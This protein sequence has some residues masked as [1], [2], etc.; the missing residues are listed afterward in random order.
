MNRDVVAQI[1]ADLAQIAAREG[2]T[3]LLA[4]ESGSRAWGFPSPDSDYDCRF[5]FLRAPAAYLALTPPRD[6][7][8]LPVGPVFDV[9][10]WDV[11]K[12]LR[13]LLKGNAVVNEWL[14]SPIVYGGEAAFRDEMAALAARVGC[15][16]SVARHYLSM[17]RSALAAFEAEGGAGPLKKLFYA[18][19]PALALGW[20]ARRPDA[21]NPPMNLQRLLAESPLTAGAQAEIAALVARKAQTREMGRAAAAPALLALIEEALGAAEAEVARGGFGDKGDAATREAEADRFFVATLNRVFGLNI[22][23]LRRQF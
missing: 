23:D 7:I 1:D 8:E 18:L 13:L 9:S 16:A 5:L 6:V 14:A 20:L 11:Q 22:R 4:V 15:R 17:G 10:G 21:A 3:I 2:V 19:R 12:A